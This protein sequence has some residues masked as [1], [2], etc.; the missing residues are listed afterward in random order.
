MY[1]PPRLPRRA[2]D[3]FA[4]LATLSLLFIVPAAHANVWLD[5]VGQ[6]WLWSTSESAGDTLGGTWWAHGLEPG[7][8]YEMRFDVRKVQ[9]DVALLLA[10]EN[11][12]TI[13]TTGT[14]TYQFSVASSSGKR[15]MMF[16]ARSADALISAGSIVVAETEPVADPVPGTGGNGTDPQG[17]I[18]QNS[19][20]Q[21]W[22][23]E[24]SATAGQLMAG[25]WWESALQPGVTYRIAFDVSAIRGTAGVLVGDN[26]VVEI[27]REGSYSFDFHISSEG[28]RRLAFQSRAGDVALGVNNIWVT[29]SWS[30]PDSTVGTSPAKGHYVSFARPRNLRTEMLELIQA[31]HLAASNYALDIAQQLDTALRTTGVSGIIMRLPWRDL[32]VGDG[33]YDWRLLDANI[34]VAGVYGLKFIVQIGDRS[35]DGTDILPA[36]FPSEYALPS[37]SGALTGVVAK[38]W[39]PYVYNR[40]IRLNRAIAARYGDQAGFGGI[41]T[42]ETAT[43]YNGN[44][45]S[46]AAYRHALTQ[47][48]IQSQAAMPNHKLFMYLNFLRGGDNSDMNQDARVALVRDLPHD[49]LVIGGP[50]ISPDV[51]GM[52]RSVTNYRVHV[53]KTMPAVEQF[54]HLQHVDHGHRGINVKSNTERQAFLEEIARAR[55][56]ERQSWFTGEPA[57][58]ELD[59]LRDPA[60]NRVQLHPSHV[61]GQLWS[62]E[63]LF[64]FGQRNFDCDYTF[65]HYREFPEPGEY[66]W[67][68]TQLVIRDNPY[69]YQ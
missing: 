33:R 8:H 50:D 23:Y 37:G 27:T 53:R 40:I 62:L 41:A 24:T 32:E 68:D 16:V 30:Q 49:N 42:T 22:F 18:W 19:F 57:V 10:D 14:R 29:Q 12:L 54:C 21:Q 44:D 45:Y 51:S 34:E 5:S 59:D 7:K 31:P 25:T 15:R 65:W 64:A 61:L 39:D 63:E 43:G 46:P 67:Y 17:N 66:G 26:E 55:H 2:R 35:F 28:N 9:G 52:P 47:I 13:D 38:R 11:E 69:Y 6:T 58:F 36:Y 48:A 3:R 60:G 56:R 1:A 20:G 4:V